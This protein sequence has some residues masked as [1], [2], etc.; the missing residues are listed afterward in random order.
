MYPGLPGHTLTS[1]LAYLLVSQTGALILCLVPVLQTG[2]PSQPPGATQISIHKLLRPI[3]PSPV[4]SRS[5]RGLRYPP[6][7]SLFTVAWGGQNTLPDHPRGRAIP[8]SCSP[9]HAWA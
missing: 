2:T 6:Q 3:L 9:S 5:S 8:G 1:T 4:L 7:L